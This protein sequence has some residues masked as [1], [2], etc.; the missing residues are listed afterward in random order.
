MRKFV[1]LAIAF[2]LLSCFILHSNAFFCWS[3][4]S[5]SDPIDQTITTLVVCNETGS[6][7]MVSSCRLIFNFHDFYF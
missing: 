2:I 3:C 1:V 7:C 4:S 5:C 6:S